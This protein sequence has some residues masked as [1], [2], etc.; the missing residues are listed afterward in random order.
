[1]T[2]HL[3]RFIKHISDDTGHVHHCTQATVEIHQ[4]R[5]RDRAIEAAKHRFARMRK[6][7]RWDMHA[8]T[9]EVREESPESGVR[10]GLTA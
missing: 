8:D 1:M 10:G 6:I 7:K 5:N 4:A 2:R 3:I 9:F